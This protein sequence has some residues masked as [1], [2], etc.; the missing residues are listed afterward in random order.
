MKLDYE[1]VR[2]LLIYVEE[3]INFG[4]C[5]DT[6]SIAA[7]LDAPQRDVKYTAVKLQEAGFLILNTADWATPVQVSH[8]CNIYGLTFAGHEYL[9]AIKNNSVWS[10][11]VKSIIH[12]GGA[13]TFQLVGSAAKVII[14]QGLLSGI[15]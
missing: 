1:L 15:S 9:N 14:E 13:F 8:I 5:K 11:I 2:K 3:N 4:G 7:E 12:N 6:D 10:K